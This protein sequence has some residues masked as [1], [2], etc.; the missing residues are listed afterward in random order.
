MSSKECRS[1]HL[2]TRLTVKCLNPS[3]SELL[4]LDKYDF[5]RNVGRYCSKECKP[6]KKTGRIL[7]CIGCG[8]D[9]YVNPRHAGIR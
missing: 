4:S 5:E 1:N 7:K 2:G 9:F 3:C 8:E 6:S